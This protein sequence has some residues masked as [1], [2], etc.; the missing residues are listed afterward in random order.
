[1]SIRSEHSEAN[2]TMGARM[3]IM[4]SWDKKVRKN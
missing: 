1:M 3:L 4:I 2:G